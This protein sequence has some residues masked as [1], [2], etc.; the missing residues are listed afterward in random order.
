MYY[1]KETTSLPN[2]VLPT[3]EVEFNVKLMTWIFYI[4]VM[5][6]KHFTILL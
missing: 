6:I 2:K 5:R 3:A 4:F 1:E